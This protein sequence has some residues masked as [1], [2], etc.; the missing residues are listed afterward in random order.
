MVLVL[1]EDMDFV[2]ESELVVELNLLALLIMRDEMQEKLI[3]EQLFLE[4]E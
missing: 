1:L 2:E 3:E 4:L